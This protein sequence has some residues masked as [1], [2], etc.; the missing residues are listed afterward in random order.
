MIPA[1]SL[2]ICSL[3]FFVSLG[4]TSRIHSI[5]LG[6]LAFTFIFIGN[7]MPKTT[8]NITMGIKIR[9][10]LASDENWNATHRFAG[11]VYVGVG[12]LCI[13]GMFLPLGVFLYILFGIIL[14]T[15]FLPVLYSYLF[16]KKQL[17]NGEITKEDIEKGYDFVKNKKALT[18][19]TVCILAVLAIGLPILMFAGKVETLCG[20]NSLRVSA[21]FWSDLELSYDEIDF[22]E[23]REN[24]VGGDRIAGYGSAK[25]LLGRF[26]SDELGIYTRYTYGKK[27]PCIVLKANGR[28]FVIGEKTA[29]EAKAVYDRILS[30]ISE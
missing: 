13:V 23:Y 17:A 26:R 20:E 22:I 9:W 15:V 21:T 5:I 16:Y 7:Y 11:K 6:V 4:H 28:T 30:E 18:I 10:A 29:A 27:L 25:L 3:L 19:T 14:I 8:R 2:F 1:I 24:G 12:V